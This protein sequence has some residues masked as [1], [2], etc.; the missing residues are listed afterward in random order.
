MPGRAQRRAQLTL[1]FLSGTLT[2]GGDWRPT[3]YESQRSG[4]RDG[5]GE[6]G[7]RAWVGRQYFIGAG[8]ETMRQT[9]LMLAGVAATVALAACGQGGSAPIDL[10]RELDVAT[11]DSMGLLPNRGATQFVSAIERT[12]GWAPAATPVKQPTPSPRA[13][14]QPVK[15]PVRTGNEGPAVEAVVVAPKA[16]AATPAPTPTPTPTPHRRG[17]YKSVGEVIRN[18][19]FPINPL[20][21]R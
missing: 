4:E 21:I 11:G 3:G 7:G 15:T 2:F 1:N 20:T 10:G 8:G 19:P 17:G 16:P 13:I 9:R 14:A 6:S 12:P 18:A 5:R